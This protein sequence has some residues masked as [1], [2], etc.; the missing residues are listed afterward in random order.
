VWSAPLGTPFENIRIL[1]PVVD[2]LPHLHTTHAD[3]RAD[4]DDQV[5]RIPPRLLRHLLQGSPGYAL[6]RAPPARVNSGREATVVPGD[7]DRNAVRRDDSHRE[8]GDS[9]E[10]RVPFRRFVRE[11]IIG[12]PVDP[13]GVGLTDPADRPASHPCRGTKPSLV[14]GAGFPEREI[15]PASP[16]RREGVN[17]T[18]NLLETRGPEEGD[19]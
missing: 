5:L 3:V 10:D 8:S 6:R 14:I 9:G 2:L 1:K 18:G 17:D 12:N 11:R 15:G 19:V 16:A 7:E 4:R 13:V